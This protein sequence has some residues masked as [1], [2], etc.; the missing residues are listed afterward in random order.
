[1]N[2]NNTS[3][4]VIQPDYFCKSDTYQKAGEFPELF[5]KPYGKAYRGNVTINIKDDYFSSV[6]YFREVVFLLNDIETYR[7]SIKSNENSPS[8]ELIF[9][10]IK[11]VLKTDLLQMELL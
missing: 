2:I 11:S 7:M 3:Y 10:L 8:K 6:T 9:Y 5:N 4:P 1:M